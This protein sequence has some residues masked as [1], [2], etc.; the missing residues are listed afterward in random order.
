[1]SSKIVNIRDFQ[2]KSTEVFFSKEELN[3]LLSIYGIRIATG[4]WCDYAIEQ[5]NGIIAFSVFKNA[6]DAPAYTV[7]KCNKPPRSGSGKFL[8]LSGPE[9]IIQTDDITEIYDFFKPEA[10]ANF[11]SLVK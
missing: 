5:R 11:I 1:M 10:K 6:F 3:Q 2:Q 8:L 4:E 9:K 7:A